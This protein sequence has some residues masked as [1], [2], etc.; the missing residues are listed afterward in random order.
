MGEEY[1]LGGKNR[2]PAAHSLRALRHCHSVVVFIPDL[3]FTILHVLF[4]L[5]LLLFSLARWKSHEHKDFHHFSYSCASTAG[6]RSCPEQ[7]LN[8]Y[9]KA[10]L[11][12]EER[13]VTVQET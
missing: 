12:V 5:F 1:F 6:H 9:A 3:L 4:C 2:F 11:E 10:E 7:A 13:E 8:V